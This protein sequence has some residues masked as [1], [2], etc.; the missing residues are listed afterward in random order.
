M[1]SSRRPDPADG[2]VRAL[3]AVLE[4]PIAPALQGL[5]V[6]R[7][8]GGGFG[9]GV[10]ARGGVGAAGAVIFYLTYSGTA[11]SLSLDVESGVNF[12]MKV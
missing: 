10:A 3:D 5:G 6:V 12:H 8:G 4:A 7:G 2:A 9:S 1:M 11:T